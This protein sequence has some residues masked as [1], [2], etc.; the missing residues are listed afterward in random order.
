MIPEELI[1]AFIK[2]HWRE[3]RDDSGDARGMGLQYDTYGGIG[4]HWVEDQPVQ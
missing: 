4:S 3:V 2:D 1:D